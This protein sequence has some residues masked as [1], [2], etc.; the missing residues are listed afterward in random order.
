LD[1]TPYSINQSF[2]QIGCN[3]ISHIAAVTV[4]IV[5]L[6]TVVL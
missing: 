3:H 2:N 1:V 4:T 5:M 6:I